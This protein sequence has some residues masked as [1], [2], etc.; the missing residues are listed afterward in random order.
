MPM[1]LMPDLSENSFV[2]FQAPINGNSYAV[3]VRWDNYCNCAF[4]RISLNGESLLPDDYPLV[5]NGIIDIDHRKLPKLTFLHKE[6]QNI[7][8]IKETFKDFGLYY[9]N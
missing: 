5:C 9:E 7:N 2:E 6:L 8:P 1:I 4:M 3:E